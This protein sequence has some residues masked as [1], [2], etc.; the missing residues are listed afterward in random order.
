MD[1]SPSTCTEVRRL[2]PLLVLVVGPCVRASARDPEAP[3][4]FFDGLQLLLAVSALWST[5]A[6]RDRRPYL[7]FG[8]TP[9]RAVARE[10]SPTG[11]R[12]QILERADRLSAHASVWA[13]LWSS[14]S[15]MG[16]R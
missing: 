1:G 15:P 8:F 4:D 9:N 12:C 11:T 14:C 6:R 16:Y 2:D 3:P 10:K 5:V 7:E 13:C